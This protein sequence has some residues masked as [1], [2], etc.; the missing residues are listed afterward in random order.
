VN[1][2]AGDWLAARD[3]TVPPALAARMAAAVDAVPTGAGPDVPGRLAHAALD[4]LRTAFDD[5]DDRAAALHLLAA[6]ALVTA[7]CEAA[8]QAGLATLEEL[9][10]ALS[11]QRL[12]AL[13]PAVDAGTAPS[14]R[15]GGAGHE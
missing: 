9:C 8:A 4:C 14:R 2:T 6:D 11:P 15:S 10:D 5:C 12:A 1:A 3:G 7:A 13:L